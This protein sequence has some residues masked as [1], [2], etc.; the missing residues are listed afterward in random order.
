MYIL[1]CQWK[2]KYLL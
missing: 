2:Y 1:C